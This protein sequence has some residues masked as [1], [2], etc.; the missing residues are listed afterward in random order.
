MK[1][2]KEEWRP[3]VGYE[4]RYEVSN[5]GRVR[6]LDHKVKSS[7]YTGGL[8]SRVYPGKEL[9]PYLGRGDYLFVH[10]CRDN[11]SR[12]YPIHRL[13]AFSFVSNPEGKPQIDHIDGDRKNNNAENLRWCTCEENINNPN[14]LPSRCKRVVQINANDDSVIRTWPSTISVSRATGIYHVDACC[15]GIRKTAGG[16]KWKYENE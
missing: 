3:V 10:L 8:W 12:H 11:K 14:T 1:P 15:R 16:Y 9:T 13:V 7:N 5:L 4:G 2:A 6:S